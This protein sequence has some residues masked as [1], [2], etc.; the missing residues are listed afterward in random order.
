[1]Y[2]EIA[3]LATQKGFLSPISVPDLTRCFDRVWEKTIDESHFLTSY[4]SA[5]SPIARWTKIIWGEP[6]KL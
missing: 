3:A 2:E 5:K 6:N 4:L 1:M